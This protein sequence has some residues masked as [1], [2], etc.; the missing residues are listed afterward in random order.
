MSL[1]RGPK[2][3]YDDF[4]EN[5]LGDLEYIP[6]IYENHLPKLRRRSGM[7]R[8]VRY[9]LCMGKCNRPDLGVYV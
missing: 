8:N 2:N 6:D 1:Y 9:T 7:F 3:Q 5:G 4:L